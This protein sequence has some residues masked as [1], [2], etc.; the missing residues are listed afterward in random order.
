METQTAEELAAAQ[1][2]GLEAAE[3]SR[4]A[5]ATLAAVQGGMK[6]ER[7]RYAGIRQIVALAGLSPARTEEV[8]N[9]LIDG[10]ATLE[11]ARTRV[12]EEM[13]AKATVNPQNSHVAITRDRTD[14]FRAQVEAGIMLRA[15]PSRVT[16]EERLA[17]RDYAGLT[18]IEIARECLSSQGVKVKGMYPDQI[19]RAALLGPQGAPEF[20]EGAGMITTSDLPGILANVANKN[21]R[22]G[23]E[24]APK[25]FMPFCRMVSA[26]DFKPRASVQ[27]SDLS[28]FTKINEKG[29]FHRGSLTDNKETYSLSTYGEIIPITRKTLINDDL[30]ALTR[31]PAGLGVA[32]ANLESD[33]VWAVITANAAMADAVA[34]FHATHKN[35]NTANALAATALDTARAAMRVVKAPKGTILNLTPK[36]LLVPAALEGTALKLVFPTQLAAN[37]VTGVI[38]QWIMNLIPIVEP[39]LDAAANGTTNWFVVADP[40]QIDTIEYCYLEGQQG[41]YVET[42]YGFEVDGV[43]IKARLDFAA[44]VVEFRGLQK[45]TA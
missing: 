17:G 13:A 21:L 29:E 18:L 25:T 30:N 19:A 4:Q 27:L 32:A 26:K 37:V 22:Q 10:G 9:E 34:L 5:S 12:F 45:N 15:D 2:A 36:Y 44:A 1:Q 24:A 6:A 38:P 41:V 8:T 11:A 31:V 39:R 28:A 16:A 14:T 23:Y 43:E 33:T 40:S 35:L 20:F 7:A 3:Q 42:R